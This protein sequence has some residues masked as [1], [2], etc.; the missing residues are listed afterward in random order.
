MSQAAQVLASIA[1]DL[2][3]PIASV[4]PFITTLEDNW[5]DTREAL[6]QMSDQDFEKLKIPLRIAS[7]IR[8][9]LK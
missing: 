8:E 6:S 9:K 7:L 5:Y 1:K 3:K 2:N 4:Q